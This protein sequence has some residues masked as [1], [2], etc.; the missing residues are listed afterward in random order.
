MRAR[1]VPDVDIIREL[2]LRSWARENY[3]PAYARREGWHPIVL[4]EMERRDREPGRLILPETVPNAAR[5]PYVPL[6]PTFHRLDQPHFEHQPP[7]LLGRAA[8]EVGL[9]IPG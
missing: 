5:S 8:V 4:D 3:V 6:L 2:R 9:F 7:H 1:S